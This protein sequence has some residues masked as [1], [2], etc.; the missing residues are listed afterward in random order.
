MLR[1]TGWYQTVPSTPLMPENMRAA[2]ATV[3]SSPSTHGR[4]SPLLARWPMCMCTRLRLSG[5]VSL[6]SAYPYPPALVV[7]T[8]GRRLAGRSGQ[9]ASTEAAFGCRRAAVDPT[10]LNTPADHGSPR[11]VRSMNGEPVWI[12][13][14]CCS[15]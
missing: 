10:M 8:G 15:A 13:A 5:A 1:R 14:S 3:L 12:C 9:P 6:S 11:P 7:V 2:R 4:G